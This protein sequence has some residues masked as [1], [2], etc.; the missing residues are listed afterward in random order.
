MQTQKRSVSAHLRIRAHQPRCSCGQRRGKDQ[1]V[2]RPERHRR[3]RSITNRNNS[4][5]FFLHS[6]FERHYVEECGF[7]VGAKFAVGFVRKVCW[8]S[9]CKYLCPKCPMH[10]RQSKL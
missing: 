4:V 10:F 2:E 6:P 9:S 3:T 8:N 5:K 1:S 7:D